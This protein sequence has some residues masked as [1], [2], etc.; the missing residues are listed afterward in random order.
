MNV[1]HP[2][3]ACLNYGLLVFIVFVFLVIAS[4]YK[5]SKDAYCRATCIYEILDKYR[6]TYDIDACSVAPSTDTSTKP[7]TGVSQVITRI[8]ASVAQKNPL[9]LLVVAFP[10][11]SANHLQKTLGPLPDMA[12]RKSLEYLQSMLDEIKTVYAPGAMLTIFCDGIPFASLFNVSQS[13][14]Y[15]YEKALQAL[16]RD[17]PNIQLYTSADFMKDHKVSHFEEALSFINATSAP[18]FSQQPLKDTVRKRVALEFDYP[19]GHEFLKHHS[20]DELIY[21]LQSRENNLQNYISKAF[22]PSQFLRL[23]VHFSPD[24]QK[25]LGIRLSPTSCITPYHGVLKE[26]KN[27]S[28]TIVFRKE[29]NLAQYKLVTKTVHGIQCPYFKHV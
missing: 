8:A 25:K 16:V 3:H 6:I 26:E 21:T 29:V 2:R 27:G 13:T 28:W 14:V 15:N 24:I 23:T 7:I 11:K 12:E 10:F 5:Q 20:L 18:L 19:A 9:Q 22:P 4:Y 1:Y 17:L